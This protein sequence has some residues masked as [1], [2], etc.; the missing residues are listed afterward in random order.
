MTKT[1]RSILSALTAAALLA[2]PALAKS[3]PKMAEC[4]KQSA[5][6]KGDERKK[7][8]S[9]CLSGGGSSAKALTPQQQKMKDCNAQ[10]KG[11]KG[12]ERKDFMKSC[13]S[14]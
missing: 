10:A 13:L 9:E 6:M 2:G 11:M 4:T 1:L 5:G 14:K 8:M 12:K 3:N 7:F